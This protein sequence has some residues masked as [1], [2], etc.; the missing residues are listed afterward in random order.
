[1]GN[2]VEYVPFWVY[3]IESPSPNDLYYNVNEGEIL[4][5]T[6]PLLGIETIKKLT[7]TSDLFKQALTKDILNFS[8]IFKRVPV[9][10]ISA[11]GDR[12]GLSLTDGSTIGWEQLKEFLR[13]INHTYK[14]TLIICLSACESWTGCKMTMCSGER[15]FFYLIGTIGAPSWR[16][17]IVGFTVFYNLL[18]K[19]Q[20]FESIIEII[21]Q[22]SGGDYFVGLEAKNIQTAYLNKIEESFQKWLELGKSISKNQ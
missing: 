1:M 12:N 9:I 13:P 11:H 8:N 3:I 15:P 19:K 22:A 5:K 17:T 6:F 4:E 14:D 16:E 2:Q 7:T 10:H 20:K 21:N 18:M